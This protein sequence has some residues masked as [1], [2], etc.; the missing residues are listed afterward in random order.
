VA[1]LPPR[2]GKY[3]SSLIAGHELKTA[4]K[5]AFEIIKGF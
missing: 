2:Q 1:Y 5:K 3:L 4:K